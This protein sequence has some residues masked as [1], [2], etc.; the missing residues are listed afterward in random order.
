MIEL[1]FFI[2]LA[3]ILLSVLLIW[4]SARPAAP[5]KNLTGIQLVELIES[6]NLSLPSVLMAARIFAREDWHFVCETDRKGLRELFVRE[7][8][9]LA[10]SWIRATQRQ[11][12]RVLRL[13]R[14]AAR[15][16]NQ[17]R[18]ASEAKILLSYAAF[19]VNCVV[20][21]FLI[22]FLGPFQARRALDATLGLTERLVRPTVDLLAGLESVRLDDVRRRWER[23]PA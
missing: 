21:K 16:S 8:S 15:A 14:L 3:A 11:V 7:R 5:W 4:V 2:V 12:A 17:A 10:L 1:I 6:F 18:F 9:A 20:L 19:Q 22:W 13:Y 23:M